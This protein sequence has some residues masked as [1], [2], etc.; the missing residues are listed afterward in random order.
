M[1]LI[2]YSDWCIDDNDNVGVIK[3]IKILGVIIKF[4]WIIQNFGGDKANENFKKMIN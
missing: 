2:V 4:S 3:Q 1:K